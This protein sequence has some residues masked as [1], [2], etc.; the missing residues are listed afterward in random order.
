LTVLLSLF[1]QQNKISSSSH[2]S[3]QNDGVKEVYLL[4]F[5]SLFDPHCLHYK[6]QRPFK[7]LKLYIRYE[8]T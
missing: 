1:V 6:H 3:R 7:M 4:P 5:N 2:K 8:Q